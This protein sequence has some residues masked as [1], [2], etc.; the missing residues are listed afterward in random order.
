MTAKSS[1]STSGRSSPSSLA[2]SRE[3]EGRSASSKSK[4]RSFVLWNWLRQDSRHRFVHDEG[5]HSVGLFDAWDFTS[6]ELMQ[7]QELQRRKGLGFSDSG[8]LIGDV[9][10]VALASTDDEAGV[11]APRDL[12]QLPDVD[13]EEEEKEEEGGGE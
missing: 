3:G 8:E 4:S 5:G 13:E 11:D 1:S 10:S 9:T 2:S 7:A 6:A 12:Q